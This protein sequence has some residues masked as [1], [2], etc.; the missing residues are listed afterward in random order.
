MPKKY[1]NYHSKTQRTTSVSK[2]I[3]PSVPKCLNQNKDFGGYMTGNVEKTNAPK[4]PV[5]QFLI[6][7]EKDGYMI[8]YKNLTAQ[9]D[10]DV[11][12]TWRCMYSDLNLS[13]VTRQHFKPQPTLT[14]AVEAIESWTGSKLPD[15][16]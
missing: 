14:K 10:K 13:P 5:F 6:K 3:P 4:H 12:Y 1:R 2:R 9:T 7:K 11:S 16:R 8:Y 15:V